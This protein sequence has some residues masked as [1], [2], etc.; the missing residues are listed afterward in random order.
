M[1]VEYFV[2]KTNYLFSRGLE[3]YHPESQG[4]KKAG[5]GK[6][7]R[8]LGSAKTSPRHG[9]KPGLPKSNSQAERSEID[10]SKV[11][12]T[13]SG[14]VGLGLIGCHATEL[15]YTLNKSTFDSPQ[16]PP[17]ISH[18]GYHC[19][20]QLVFDRIDAQTRFW[21]LRQ[22]RLS[23]W[24]IADPIHVTMSYGLPPS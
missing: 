4:K 23:H 8:H 3:K 21:V 6:F 11:V 22:N 12:Y 2:Y 16:V 19:S 20:A 5:I 14:T 7:F 1:A 9:P 10:G 15:S 18:F 24:I 17:C 13:E